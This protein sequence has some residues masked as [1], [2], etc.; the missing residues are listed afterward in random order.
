MNIKSIPFL[1][2]ILLIPIVIFSC[3]KEKPR[4]ITQYPE[5]KFKKIAVNC[6]QVK[7]DY[8]I[9]IMLNNKTSLNY[10]IRRG[11]TTNFRSGPRVLDFIVKQLDSSNNNL[12]VAWLIHDINYEGYINRSDADKLL[13]MMLLKANIP[14]STAFSVF[15]A[16]N[17]IGSHAYSEY[18]NNL[19]VDFQALK[20]L[21]V[22]FDKIDDIFGI[23]KNTF[24]K[25]MYVVDRDSVI[26]EIKRLFPEDADKIIESMNNQ[27][28]PVD[29]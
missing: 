2:L 13:Y 11:Y 7:D 5:L 22:K 14:N 4:E 12:N 16:L 20:L 24:P 3:C 10:K 18:K 9:D 6:W 8:N 26:M 15:L 21:S 23:E 19:L 1:S 28:D 25:E 17:A 27:L 29:R